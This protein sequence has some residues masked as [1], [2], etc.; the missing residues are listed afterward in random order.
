MNETN[1]SQQERQHA[2]LKAGQFVRKKIF[3][4][5]SKIQ[6]FRLKNEIFENEEGALSRI[7]SG[8]KKIDSR[9]AKVFSREFGGAE[10][11][12]I[13]LEHEMLAG[14]C[15][16]VPECADLTPK[17]EFNVSKVNEDQESR[18]PGKLKITFQNNS[19]SIP[20]EAG[21]EFVADFLLAMQKRN[22]GDE[23]TIE[24]E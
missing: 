2:R 13:A 9:F 14:G 21:G 10:S 17:E 16:Y 8:K 18:K 24:I 11:Y 23:P 3:G 22:G 1:Y 12:W 7:L 6:D 20:I 4:K 5:Y 15:D 19:Y